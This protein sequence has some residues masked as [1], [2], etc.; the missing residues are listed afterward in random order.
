MNG[1][2]QAIGSQALLTHLL[3]VVAPCDPICESFLFFG[4]FFLVLLFWPHHTGCEILV[5]RPEIEPRPSAV[6]APSPNHWT[7]REVPYFNHF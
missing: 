3:K 5:P 2:N 6:K 7:A 1:S 4:S